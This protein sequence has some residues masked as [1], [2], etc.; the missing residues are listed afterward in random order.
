MAATP[1][2][3]GIVNRALSLL[4]STARVSSISEDSSNVASAARAHWD[5]AVRMA[6]ADHPWNFAI[7]RKLVSAS[8]DVPAFGHERQFALPSDCLRWL[9]PSP[10]EDDYYEAVNENGALLTSAEAPLPVRYISRDAAD[11]I[12]DWPPH[13]AEVMA[14]ALAFYMANA[15]TQSESDQGNAEARFDAALKQ[16]KRMDALASGKRTRM[17]VVRRSGWL[18]SR[19][20][21]YHYGTRG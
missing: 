14:H 7:R 20:V 18:Q 19:R 11:A 10:D 2:Q 16:A 13:F 12:A 9:P 1:T 15:V 17:N 4:G 21:P 5:D 8:A 3:T 6:L